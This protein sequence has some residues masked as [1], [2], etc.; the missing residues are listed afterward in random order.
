MRLERANGLAL[1]QWLGGIGLVFMLA[2]MMGSRALLS[3]GM[4]VLAVNIFSV[5][6]RVP[7]IWKA[8]ISWKPLPVLGLLFFLYLVSGLWSEQTNDFWIRIRIKLPFLIL[9]L[10]IVAIP[11][12]D[13]RE[14]HRLLYLFFAGVLL[15]VLYSMVHIFPQLFQMADAYG[16]GQVMATPINHIRFSLLVVLAVASGV[17]L[18]QK[19]AFLWYPG[20]RW[21]ILSGVLILSIYLHLLAVRTGLACVYILALFTWFRFSLKK[22]NRL[23]GIII[24]LAGMGISFLAYQSIPTLQQKVAYTWWSLEQLGNPEWV[25]QTSDPKRI[26]SVHAGLEVGMANPWLGVGV[27]DIQAEVDQFY[28]QYYPPLKGINLLPHNQFVFVFAGLGLMGL[29]LFIWIVTY[30]WWYKAAYQDYFVSAFHLILLCS[31]LVEMT[32]ETQFGTAVYL[33]FLL[34]ALRYLMEGE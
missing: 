22:G 13:E 27:G 10:A 12:L 7:D 11:R 1:Q 9:P 5:P 16:K 17:Y 19:K 2:G 15:F 6:S 31:F 18:F 34:P 3:I 28:E 29:L 33:T 23:W 32:L 20:E 24:L 26:A 21:F 14:W 30:P 25:R 8:F 4:I